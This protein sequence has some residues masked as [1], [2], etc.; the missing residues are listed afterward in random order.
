MEQFELLQLPASDSPSRSSLLARLRRA[1]TSQGSFIVLLDDAQATCRRAALDAVHRLFRLP[2]DKK[3]KLRQR[4]A[5]ALLRGY[6]T[7]GAESGSANPELKEGFS[8]GNPGAA[9]DKDAPL[10]Q[11]NIWPAGPEGGLIREVSVGEFLCLFPRADLP[12]GALVSTCRDRLS[13]N[14]G[15]AWPK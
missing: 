15:I 13:N 9:G 8:F 12:H 11:R 14:I 7:P 1:V 10:E 5:E 4:D 2:S 3:E 6:I